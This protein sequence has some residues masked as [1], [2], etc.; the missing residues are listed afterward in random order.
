MLI[1]DGKT[2]VL[3][4][5]LRCVYLRISRASILDDLVAG[6]HTLTHSTVCDAMVVVIREVQ[7]ETSWDEHHS[8]LLTC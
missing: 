4:E 2:S 3:V 8:G 6:H 5:Y 7:D 1:Q